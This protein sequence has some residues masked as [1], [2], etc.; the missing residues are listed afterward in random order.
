[1]KMASTINKFLL[2]HKLYDK[3]IT[4]QSKEDWECVDKALAE[5]AKMTC[6]EGTWGVIKNSY[7]DYL[8]NVSFFVGVAMATGTIAAI[9]MGV[10]LVKKAKDE[11][12]D[13][14]E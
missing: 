5:L 10:K 2:D 14:V 1:M 8:S 12:G 6:E 7:V 13:K 11:L 4:M 3:C 9:G